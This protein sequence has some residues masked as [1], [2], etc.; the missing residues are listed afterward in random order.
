MNALAASGIPGVSTVCGI[1]S[2]MMEL[3]RNLR[4]N[5]K[6][7]VTFKSG[8]IKQYFCSM[9][10]V[11]SVYRDTITANQ[12]HAASQLAKSKNELKEAFLNFY[13]EEHVFTDSDDDF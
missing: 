9:A 13:G 11:G 3:Y 8:T 12:Q 7:P 5:P 10:G 6:V 4:N 2:T 1:F